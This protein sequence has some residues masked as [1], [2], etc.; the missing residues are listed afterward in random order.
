[1]KKEEEF[2]CYFVF[3]ERGYGMSMYHIKLAEKLW[4]AISSQRK[5]LW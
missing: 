1:M 5:K 2:K 4:M 3:A